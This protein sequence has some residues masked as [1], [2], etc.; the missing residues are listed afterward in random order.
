[1]TEEPESLVPAP[2]E[3]ERD[4]KDWEERRKVA[5]QAWRMGQKLA[6]EQNRKPGRG[7]RIYRRRTAAR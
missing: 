3:G 1:M 6:A 4:E 2:P 7:R 5:L